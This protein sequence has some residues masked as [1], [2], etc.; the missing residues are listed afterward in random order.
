MTKLDIA[1]GD[2]NGEHDYVCGRV[3]RAQ[4]PHRGHGGIGFAS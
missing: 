2:G 4:H 1:I 3:V